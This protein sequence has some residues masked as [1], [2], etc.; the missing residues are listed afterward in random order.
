M[1]ASKFLK[2]NMEKS[3]TVTKFEKFLKSITIAYK[4]SLILWINKKKIIISFLGVT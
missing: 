2:K 4:Q 1:L 3:K